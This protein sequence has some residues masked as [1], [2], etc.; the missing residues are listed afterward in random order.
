MKCKREKLSADLIRAN[1][2]TP[3]QGTKTKITC[4]DIYQMFLGVILI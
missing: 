3:A 1:R 4:G 2:S